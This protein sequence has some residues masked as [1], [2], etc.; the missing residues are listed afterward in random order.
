MLMDR[1]IGRVNKDTILLVAMG[2]H[3]PVKEYIHT[4]VDLCCGLL[5]VDF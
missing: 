5:Q 2:I 4:T 3:I 1:V